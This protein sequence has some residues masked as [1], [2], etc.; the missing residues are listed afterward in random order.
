MRQLPAPPVEARRLE[1]RQRL[2]RRDGIVA[3]GAGECRRARDG[4]NGLAKRR[5]HRMWPLD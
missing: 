4:E 5:S 2:R 1:R 3:P